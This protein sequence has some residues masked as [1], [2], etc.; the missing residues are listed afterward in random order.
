MRIT[1]THQQYVESMRKH[2]E[3]DT[4][5]NRCPYCGSKC[6]GMLL[7]KETYGFFSVKQEHYLSYSCDKCG[8]Q[9]EAKYMEGKA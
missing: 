6:L 2:Q 3:V 1:R 8:T 5:N 4:N 9:W 7:L